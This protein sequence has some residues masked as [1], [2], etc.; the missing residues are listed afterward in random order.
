[1]ICHFTRTQLRPCWA[2]GWLFCDLHDNIFLSI[3]VIFFLNFI[4]FCGSFRFRR[5][6]NDKSRLSDECYFVFPHTRHS[7]LPANALSFSLIYSTRDDDVLV[8]IGPRVRWHSE[9]GDGR[10]NARARAVIRY[11]SEFHV[12][13]CAFCVYARQN[14]V[15]VVGSAAPSY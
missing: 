12:R 4:F 13:A 11:R 15:A 14:P 7:S 2:G 10:I 5:K 9:G 8:Y 1:M 6:F 3:F